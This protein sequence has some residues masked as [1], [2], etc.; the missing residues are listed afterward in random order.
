MTM[1]PTTHTALA[2]TR[3]LVLEDDRDVR[4]MLSLVL[5]S[6]GAHPLEA[7]STEEASAMIAAGRIDGLVVDWNLRGESGESF[8]R[9]VETE[10]PGLFRRTLVITGDLLRRGQQQTE[11]RAGRPVLCKPFRPPQLLEALSKVLTEA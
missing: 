1:S 2:G 5:S 11:R 9:K 3:I 4:Q 8:L 7:G 10:T 6:A